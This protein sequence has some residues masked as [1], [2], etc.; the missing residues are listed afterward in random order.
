MDETLIVEGTEDLP[1]L[2]FVDG[3]PG[4]VDAT[5]FTLARWGGPTSPFSLLHAID[6][7][8]ADFVVTPPELFFPD[9]APEVDDDLAERLDL[10]SADDAILLVIVT[11]PDRAEDAT[12][13]LAGPLV[14]NRHTR[15]AAQAVL[16]LDRYDLQAPLR[17]AASAA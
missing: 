1:E 6:L 15:Q 3:L 5:R 13:N 8:G 14:V 12:A 10:K 16:Q 7:D 9:Y 2:D 4:F 11:V 17:A